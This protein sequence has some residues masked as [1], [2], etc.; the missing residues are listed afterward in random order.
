MSLSLSLLGTSLLSLLLAGY[1]ARKYGLPPPAPKIAAIDLGTTFSSIGIYQAVTGATDIITD[2]T[3]RQSI[4]SV[5]A[6]LSN[7]TVI[8]GSKAV[9]QQEH[10]LL[11][12]IYDAKRFI[13]R[14]LSEDDPQFQADR[15]RYPFKIELDAEGRALFVIP[16][17]NNVIKK[18]TP[19]EVG[20]IIINYL[21]KAAEKKYG[22]EIIQA[23]ISVPAEFDDKQR[24]ATV[25]ALEKAGME[26]RRVISEPTAAALAYGLHK[27][28]NV[29]YIVV[30]DLGGGTLDVSILWL[31]GG[32][33]MTVAM[34]GNN[35][36]GGQDFNDR[37]QNHLIQ[38]IAD[39][40]GKVLDDKED[41]QQL[42]LAIES[43]KIQLT[44]LPVTNIDLNLR[45]LGKMHYRLTRENFELLN[46]DLFESIT[47]P[48][49]AALN[50]AEIKAS[51]IDE[52]V[53]VGGSTRIPRVR[54]VVGRYFGKAP[55][56]GVDP[57][58][59]VVTGASVQA[60]VI[61]GGWPLQVS[62]IELPVKRRK[63]HIFT[64]QKKS[65]QVVEHS[66]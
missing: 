64:G 41:I 35:R 18:I 36:L 25:L 2:E 34:A 52:I 33:F 45:S 23:V 21:R 51:E 32:M 38:H 29:E 20:G 24:N 10:N 6:F 15:R 44:T 4:P 26:S 19:E 8:V 7:G 27:K 14:K 3:G 13:G 22:N 59:A 11:R 31:Q 61:G 42:R 49:E 48:I 30:V 56:H 50:D 60:G 55:N 28:K 43:A 58:L 16:V 40:Y 57:E 65:N 53:L 39:N 5:V 12:T 66:R 1:F 63:H 17:D 47:E 37:V 62:A 9:E 54:S 46:E